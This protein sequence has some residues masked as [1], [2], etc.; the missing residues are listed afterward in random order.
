EDANVMVRPVSNKEIKDDIF[1]IDSSKASGPDGYTSEFLKKSWD[2]IGNE[3]CLVVKEFFR[4]GKLLGEVNA[5]LI[6][7]IPKVS[8][9]NK[10]SEFRPIACCNVIYKCLSKI[11]TN[12]IKN[13][14]DKIIHIR[15]AH[16]G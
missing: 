4:N 13:G 1:D 8:T 6:A 5:T 11:L 16:S 14:L 10:V 12:R 7:L 9:P 15:E 3:V 2:V